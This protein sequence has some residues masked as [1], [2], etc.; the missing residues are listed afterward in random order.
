MSKEHDGPVDLKDYEKVFIGKQFAIGLDRRSVGD[1]HVVF[2]TAIKGFAGFY[3]SAIPCAHTGAISKIYN[4][5]IVCLNCNEVI[6]SMKDFG[7]VRADMNHEHSLEYKGSKGIYSCSCGF[8]LSDQ[9]MD[10]IAGNRHNNDRNKIADECGRLLTE[11]RA[12]AAE[13]SDLRRENDR[14]KRSKK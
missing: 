11:N 2:T 8:N 12:L 14:L 5:N 10:A 3:H 1:P 6:C 9:E 13:N 7:R 4:G